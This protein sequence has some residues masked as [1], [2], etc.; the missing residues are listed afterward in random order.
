MGFFVFSLPNTPGLVGAQYM[1]RDAKVW[2][3]SVQ[4]PAGAS[5]AQES[6][7][8]VSAQISRV[9]LD[10]GSKYTIASTPFYFAP[11]ILV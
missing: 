3:A 10:S 8:P 11:T 6:A 4:I 7:L 5:M 1:L 9:N 2:F